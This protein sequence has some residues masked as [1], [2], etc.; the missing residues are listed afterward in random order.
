[1]AVPGDGACRPHRRGDHRRSRAAR[2]RGAQGEGD[3][4]AAPHNFHPICPPSSP[5]GP[6]SPSPPASP[7]ATPSPT[8][9]PPPAA[10]PAQRVIPA[11]TGGQPD[12]AD[13]YGHYRG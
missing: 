3:G 10:V 4:E 8:P 13:A 11:A 7:S 12:P 1:M 5:A 9:A 2:P 6:P